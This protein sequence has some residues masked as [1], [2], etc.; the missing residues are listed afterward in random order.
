L[1]LEYKVIP[2]EAMASKSH[3]LFCQYKLQLL[4]STFVSCNMD[5]KMLPS[6]NGFISFSL[7]ILVSVGLAWASWLALE[8]PFMGLRKN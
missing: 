5:G 6:L 2:L 1:V 7:Y 3:Y 8:K 4:F